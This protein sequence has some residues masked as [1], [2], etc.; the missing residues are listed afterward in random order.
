ML[1]EHQTAFTLQIAHKP[2]YAHFRRDLHMYVDISTQ[3]SAFATANSFV[4]FAS[5]A[6]T[7]HWRSC[8]SVKEMSSASDTSDYRYHPEEGLLNKSDCNEQRG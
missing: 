6:A 5:R 4:Y 8:I 7:S 1:I 3:H 2:R